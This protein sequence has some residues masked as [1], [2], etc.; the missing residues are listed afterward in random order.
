VTIER[1]GAPK[2]PNQKLPQLHPK[3]STHGSLT[4]EQWGGEPKQLFH[5]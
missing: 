4:V 2:M 3:R 1:I 5:D